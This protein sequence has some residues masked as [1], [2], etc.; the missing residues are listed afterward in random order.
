MKS[1]SIHLLQSKY[2]PLHP[3]YNLASNLHFY[4]ELSSGRTHINEYRLPLYNL[5]PGRQCIGTKWV[6][7]IKLD[8]NNNIDKYKCRIVAK[9][10]SQVTGLNFEKTF[11][12][13]VR[14]ESIRCLFA[15]AASRGLHMLYI[16]CKTAFLNRK[17]D[18][19]LYIKQP[20]GFID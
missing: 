9:G 17:S 3:V 20:K 11:A 18:L 7:K 6:F 13:V 1:L 15:L 4:K 2:I 12:A 10:Y 19:E 16:D 8:G 14:I 5:P